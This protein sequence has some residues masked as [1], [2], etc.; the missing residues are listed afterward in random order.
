M[1]L[2]I[3][4]RVET[5]GCAAFKNRLRIHLSYFSYPMVARYLFSFS[6]TISLKKRAHL[7]L[8]LHWMLYITSSKCAHKKKCVILICSNQFLV[9]LHSH[10]KWGH[11]IANDGTQI[12]YEIHFLD[13]LKMHI[14]LKSISNW[15]WSLFIQIISKFSFYHFLILNISSC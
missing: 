6:H 12:W 13:S 14:L 3:Y 10:V 1:C 9:H 2:N 7:S 8:F 5:M 15:N 4:L 11:K